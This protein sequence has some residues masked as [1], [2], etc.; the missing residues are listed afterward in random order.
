MILVL[1]LIVPLAGHSCFPV[2][3]A[4]FN[5]LFMAQAHGANESDLLASF[6]ANHSDRR[7]SNSSASLGAPTSLQAHAPTPLQ[8]GVMSPGFNSTSPRTSAAGATGIQAGPGQMA[9]PLLQLLKFGPASPQTT[10]SPAPASRPP[11]ANPSTHS[12]HGRGISASDLYD[13]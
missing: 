6:R 11:F 4:H 7:Q 9:N 13:A 3:A 10:P 5:L 8:A 2:F 1:F 12:V